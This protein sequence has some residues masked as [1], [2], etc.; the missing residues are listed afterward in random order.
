[1]IEELRRLEAPPPPPP[2]WRL[3]LA[4]AAGVAAIVAL[5]VI[6]VPAETGTLVIE[7]NAGHIEVV[8]RKDGA[9]IIDRKTKR[10]YLLTVGEYEVEVAETPA[11]VKLAT[12]R[13]TLVAGGKEE[14][15]AYARGQKAPPVTPRHPL[16]GPLQTGAPFTYRF[17]PLPPDPFGERP[18]EVV[19]VLGEAGP[20]HWAPVT[21]VAVSPD[22]KRAASA[23]GR[24]VLLRDPRT[25]EPLAVL[26]TEGVALSVAFDADGRR[27]AA[28]CQDD[29]GGR[30]LLFELRDGAFRPLP[31]LH[32]GEPVNAVAFAG[33]GD[34][35][36]TGGEALQVWDLATRKATR[37]VGHGDSIRGLSVGAGGRLLLSGSEN[38]AVCLWDFTDDRPI[39]LDRTGVPG[40]LHAVALSRDGKL[41]AA[42]GGEGRIQV[43]RAGDV[44]EKR[45][46]HTRPGVREETNLPGPHALAFA[47]DGR[48]LAFGGPRE[49]LRLWDVT[50]PPPAPPSEEHT[51]LSALSAA[52]TPDGTALLAGVE[53]ELQR[54]EVRGGTLTGWPGGRAGH[55]GACWSVAF[56]PDGSRA[57]TGG[58]ADRT[59]RWWDLT[60]GAPREVFVLS[61]HER[62]QLR[63]AVAPDGATVA[64]A[65]FGREVFLWECSGKAP[66]L[67]AR[68]QAT[69]S[70]P[71]RVPAFSPDGRWLFAGNDAT[72]DY[73]DLGA[74]P[75]RLRPLGSTLGRVIDLSVA[76][77]P[78]A[79]AAITEDGV[80]RLWSLGGRLP[81]ERAAI[82]IGKGER[83]P[84][85]VTLARGYRIAVSRYKDEVVVFDQRTEGGR[86][87]RTFRMPDS[88]ELKAALSPDG[89]LLA[90]ASLRGEL[91]VWD[92]SSGKE[93]YAARLPGYANQLL[94][95][96]DGR[97]LATANGDGTTYLFRVP[98]AK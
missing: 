32:V 27:L 41:A 44:L 89:R 63:V 81:D 39:K 88:W 24:R 60:G 11:G 75:P 14:V 70:A 2:R 58:H 25:F 26:P 43:W 85:K 8:V 50:G 33:P 67:L 73:W 62:H 83:A 80:A 48:T 76:R 35:L 45:T 13:F 1:V 65:G 82:P 36:V 22:G 15:V 47:P 28:G 55:R 53:T 21:G 52:F 78:A 40:P 30:V 4:L 31:P 16:L 79:L 92:V 91:R 9:T 6:Y 95:A 87:E 10:S 3:W 90:A 56:S 46:A 17:K 59:A 18:R 38:G 5:A 57:A 69:G 94:F 42:S 68:L 20:G 84:R 19:A 96:P 97:H 71:P 74:S 34:R 12:K 23:G 29:E 51:G 93:V 98:G 7:T 66:A 49:P 37:L 54:W 72:I 86:A 61:G 77:E 64:V